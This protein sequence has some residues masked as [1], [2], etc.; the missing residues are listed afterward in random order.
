M[1]E[2]SNSSGLD[3]AESPGSHRWGNIKDEK[4]E[5]RSQIHIFLGR[6]LSIGQLSVVQAP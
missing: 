3:R 5:I 4:G 1:L 6:R 2:A